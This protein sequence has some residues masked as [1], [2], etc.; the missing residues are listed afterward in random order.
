MT[1]DE[2]NKLN[3]NQRYKLLKNEGEF[4]GSRLYLNYRIHLFG[5]RGLFLEMWIIIGIDQLQW[6][7]VQTNQSILDLYVDKIDLRKILEL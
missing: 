2:F 1:G 4:I 5:C 7:E 3:L 6:I